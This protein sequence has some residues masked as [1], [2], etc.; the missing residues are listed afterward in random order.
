MK[1]ILIALFLTGQGEMTGKADY[2][3]TLEDC[4]RTKSI[5]EM[6]AAV[7]EGQV[8]VYCMPTHVVRK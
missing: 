3:A 8:E 4:E 5:Y 1:F 2:F 6:A 7:G